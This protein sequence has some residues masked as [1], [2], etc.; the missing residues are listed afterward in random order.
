[1]IDV[2]GEAL[3]SGDDADDELATVRS[4]KA[5]EDPAEEV[6]GTCC[7]GWAT[8]RPDKVF[9]PDGP[10]VDADG[11][12]RLLRLLICVSPVKL[13]IFNSFSSTVMLSGLSMRW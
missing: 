2:S 12:L 5:V 3:S 13:F 9:G 11:A 10:A 1:M 7:C 4:A 6:E 8:L